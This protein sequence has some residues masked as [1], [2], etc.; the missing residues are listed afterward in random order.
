M[1]VYFRCKPGATCIEY[2]GASSD[3]KNACRLRADDCFQNCGV[4]SHLRTLNG[5]S[6]LRETDDEL[7]ENNGC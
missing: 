6:G 2:L 7:F 4:A 3:T 5:S 1:R